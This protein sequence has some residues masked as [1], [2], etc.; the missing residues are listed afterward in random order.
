M[1]T[2]STTYIEVYY[3]TFFLLGFLGNVSSK[4]TPLKDGI[5]S[6]FTAYSYSKL[7][8]GLL[9]NITFLIEI[10]FLIRKY[11]LYLYYQPKY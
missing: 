8:N 6:F 10:M 4:K 2:R 5:L 3:T 1:R 9:G 7:F 11:L